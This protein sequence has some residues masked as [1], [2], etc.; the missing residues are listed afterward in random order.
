MTP[1]VP[2]TTL[3]PLVPDPYGA[4]E[5]VVTK[6]EFP[7][8]RLIGGE[9]MVVGERA[10]GQ[11]SRHVAIDGRVGNLVETEVGVDSSDPPPAPGGGHQH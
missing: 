4:A 3:G 8:D 9:V 6:P 1:P 2:R 10:D 5:R 11:A 7:L